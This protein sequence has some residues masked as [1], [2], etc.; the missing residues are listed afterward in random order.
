M[1]HEIEAAYKITLPE[2]E[3]IDIIDL[4]GLIALVQSTLAAD[5]KSI[6]TP[7][8]PD[9]ALGSSWE[10]GEWEAKSRSD[11]D[12]SSR[13][14]SP[15]TIGAETKG[16]NRLSTGSSTNSLL[17]FDDVLHAFQETK[18]L[19]DGRIIE[20]GQKA[21]VDEALPLQTKLTI[22]LTLDTF[23]KLKQPLRNIPS[24][25]TLAFVPHKQEQRHL[26]RHLYRMLET[27]TQTIIVNNNDTITRTAVPFAESSSSESIYQELTTRF[28]DQS[29][30]NKLTKYAGDHLAEVLS[31]KTDGVKLI[32]GSAE[33][34]ELVSGFYADWPLNQA[35]YKLMD[36]FFIQLGKKL[37]RNPSSG[38]LKI[39]EM[40]AGTGGTTK[41]LVPLLARLGVPI[42]YTF[43][44]LA[45]SFVA[46]ARKKWGK[47]YPFMKFRTHDIE[48]VP[49]QDLIGT[50]HIVVSSNAVH[51]THDLVVSTGNIRKILRPEGLLLMLEMTRTPYWVDLV[52]GLFE[53]WWLFED[54]RSHALTHEKRWRTDLQSAG[55]GLVDWTEGSTKESEIEKL[56]IAM[57]DPSSLR[58][59]TQACTSFLPPMRSKSTDCA[60]RQAVVDRFIADLVE[61][62]DLAL[63]ED[64]V[65]LKTSSPPT[66][67]T[68]ILVTGA[69]GSL[70]SHLVERCASIPSVTRVVCVNR[71]SKDE[72]DPAK[73]QK[74]AMTEKGIPINQQTAAKMVVLEADLAKPQLG[75]PEEDYA[76]LVS[77]TTHIIHN[78]WPMCFK[79]PVQRFEPCL[80]GLLNLLI[81]SRRA[82]N[83]RRNHH[84]PA[85]KMTFQFISSI[86]VVGHYPLV[87]GKAAIPEERM[88]LSSVLPTGY[89][90]A[91]YICECLLD[92]TLHKDTSRFH[93]MSVRL[94]QIA[95]ASKTGI[96]SKAEHVPFLIKSSQTLRALPDF[97]DGSVM[98]WTPVDI[99]A[100]TCVDL[101]FQPT[102]E[103]KK[104]DQACYPFYN[105]D[106]PI[107]Q[108]WSEVMGVLAEELTPGDRLSVVPFK[109]WIRLVREYKPPPS[110]GREKPGPDMMNPASL[111]ADFFEHNFR[112]MS[113]GGVLLGTTQTR[114]HSKTLARYGAVDKEYLQLVVRS[115]RER[116]F[117]R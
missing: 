87:T 60:P 23:E 31:G 100:Q 13:P 47:E 85:F 112:R 32:F 1:A 56:V 39:L 110:C 99:V 36:D 106:N 91:K 43:T 42:E 25:T 83:Y 113:C 57:A 67:G 80:K 22:A 66:P 29:T 81:L 70:G 96:W 86:A 41:R 102:S 111:L 28:P 50:Q 17:S 76:Q 104:K 27:E 40:G 92:E 11:A 9:S 37:E 51:A 79:W 2:N 15:D 82:T 103:E 58:Y 12:V 115:W 6:D 78:A 97:G 26:V 109:E 71:R 49:D 117:L 89:G 88:T 34:R 16:T 77:S 5:S 59:E 45:P 53:G 14:T 44:D 98:S 62:Y 48:K 24:G 19:T 116:G 107:R 30:A 33:G 108:L 114:E 94:G 73:R 69:T 101:L 84:D 18:S 72:S 8:T 7:T 90:D 46:A 20:Q 105:I 52:F 21:Y 65:F 64:S 35:L 55:Y 3:L 63:A 38:P 4:P 74:Q 95:G 10:I 54:G 68:T 61:G 75:L 93:A